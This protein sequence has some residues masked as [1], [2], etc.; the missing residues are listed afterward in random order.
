MINIFFIIR[1]LL[2]RFPHFP[3]NDEQ[4]S[5][6]SIERTNI[7]K[8]FDRLIDVQIFIDWKYIT[9]IYECLNKNSETIRRALEVKRLDE[10]YN[11]QPLYPQ[12]SSQQQQTRTITQ[13]IENLHLDSTNDQTA[14]TDFNP[15][16]SRRILDQV[17][18]HFSINTVTFHRIYSCHEDFSSL[19]R[20]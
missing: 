7:L 6:K 3:I 9:R 1:S 12:M 10:F 2:F 14:F 19:S 20:H 5:K 4:T 16:S 17:N 13:S 18:T 15:L 11:I 8:T